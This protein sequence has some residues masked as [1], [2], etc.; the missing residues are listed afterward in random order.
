MPWRKERREDSIYGPY[1]TGKIIIISITISITISL[2][3]YMTIMAIYLKTYN[4][5][6]ILII[7]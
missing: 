3:I 1:Y 7:Y 6:E 5:S 2:T 4:F